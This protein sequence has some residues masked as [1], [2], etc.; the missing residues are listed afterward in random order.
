MPSQKVAGGEQHRVLRRAKPV[1]SARAREIALHFERKG[2]A[3]ADERVHFAHARVRGKETKARP[4]LRSRHSSTIGAARAREVV[5]F[6]VESGRR[7]EQPRLIGIIERRRRESSWASFDAERSLDE[8]ERGALGDRRAGEH[9]AARPREQRRAQKRRDLE[10]R[11]VDFVAR[12]RR[13][14]ARPTRSLISSGGP[15]IVRGALDREV[16]VRRHRRASRGRGAARLPLH[17]RSALERACQLACTN[18]AA[19]RTTAQRYRAR[20]RRPRSR[21]ADIFR[22]ARAP[23]STAGAR[24]ASSI[25]AS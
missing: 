4:R 23:A 10:R 14:S 20:R 25:S 5:G 24:I 19:G 22:R 8:S 17:C 21:R 16:D 3:L 9:D 6:G 13:R 1:E 12:R 7:D 15:R 11:R 2:D 18:F